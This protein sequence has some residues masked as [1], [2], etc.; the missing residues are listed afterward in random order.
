MGTSLNEFTSVKAFASRIM[1]S[2]QTVYDMIARKEIA[3]IRVGKQYRIRVKDVED[4]IGRQG[5][6][7]DHE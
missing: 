6:G 7:V 4:Y 5:G 3:A 2:V 1:V